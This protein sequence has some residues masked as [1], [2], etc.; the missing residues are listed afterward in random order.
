MNVEIKNIINAV[1]ELPD[2][3]KQYIYRQLEILN[4]KNRENEMRID[5]YNEIKIGKGKENFTNILSKA[6]DVLAVLGYTEVSFVAGINP[7]FLEWFV[8]H[9]INNPSYKPQFINK[10][11]LDMLQT[12]YFITYAESDGAEPSYKDV[13]NNFYTFTD[14]SNE[15]EEQLNVNFNDYLKKLYG[16]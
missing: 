9:T 3:R 12:A 6:V 11:F 5:K 2:S 10:H 7:D 8:R 13:K 16:K 1:K 15:Y 14:K 4:N